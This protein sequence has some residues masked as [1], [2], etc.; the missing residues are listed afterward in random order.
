MINKGLHYL[1]CVGL[2]PDS[3][4]AQNEQKGILCIQNTAFCVLVN[5][6]CAE[7]LRLLECDWR[8]PHKPPL[9]LLIYFLLA[10]LST[11]LHLLP[12]YRQLFYSV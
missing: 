11:H 8:S 6:R 12:A 7:I 9:P 1:A 4:K 10:L 5:L 3:S 2:P